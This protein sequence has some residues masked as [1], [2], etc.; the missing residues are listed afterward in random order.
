MTNISTSDIYD[1]L[2]DRRRGALPLRATRS[3]ALRI[4]PI[5]SVFRVTIGSA[6]K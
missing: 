1:A 4:E 5:V 3:I 2:S 6:L